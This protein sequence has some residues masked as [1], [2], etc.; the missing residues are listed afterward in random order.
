MLVS[1][2]WDH[3]EV[4]L[5]FYLVV[6]DGLCLVLSVLIIVGLGMLVV[7]LTPHAAG[8]GVILV[9][10]LRVAYVSGCGMR[11]RALHVGM[12]TAVSSVRARSGS[13]SIPG[14][15]PEPTLDPTI[16]DPAERA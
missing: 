3:D 11:Q 8:Q 12:L 10:H 2:Y 4:S 15:T 7:H 6:L 5:F 16:G 9:R 1:F 14:G 13:L